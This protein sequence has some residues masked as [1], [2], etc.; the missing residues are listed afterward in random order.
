MTTI[1]TQTT[2]FLPKTIQVLQKRELKPRW[3]NKMAKIHAKAVK[4]VSKNNTLTKAEKDAKRAADRA[5]KN[6]AK[7]AEREAKR[8][9]DKAAKKAEKEAKI[10]ADKAAKKAEKEAKIAAD[11]A[12]KKAE[13]KAKIAADKAAKKAE[14]TVEQSVEKEERK[15]M[16]AQDK[17][18]PKKRT[19]KKKAGTN[20]PIMPSTPIAN[21]TTTLSLI[22]PDLITA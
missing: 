18:K 4:Q 3:F 13:K 8:A 15:L 16:N 1:A 5:A 10:A 20:T 22:H 14:K 9:A 7:K 21:T 2:T 11:K 6:E 19:I 17:P 12:A